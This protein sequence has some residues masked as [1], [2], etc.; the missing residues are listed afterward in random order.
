[1]SLT[2]ENA[3]DALRKVQDPELFKDIVSLNMVKDVQVEGSTVRVTVELTTPACPLKET[4]RKLL[5]ITRNSR[6]PPILH[7]RTPPNPRNSFHPTRF[8]Q[9]MYWDRTIRFWF[10][11]RKPKRSITGHFGSMETE[12]LICPWSATSMP[13]G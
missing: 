13:P 2:R 4:I 3:L 9:T 1:M 12:I 5:E 10:A 6:A 7:R 8:V 11:H